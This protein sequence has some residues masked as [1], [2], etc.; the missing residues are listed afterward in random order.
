MRRTITSVSV[1]LTVTAVAVALSWLGVRSVLRDTVFEAPRAP[2]LTA[3]EDL[4]PSPTHAA[5]ATAPAPI[6]NLISATNRTTSAP[7]TTPKP[8]PSTPPGTPSPPGT[9]STPSTPSAPATQG[10][11]APPAAAI[12]TMGWPPP[13]SKMDD[14]GETRRGRSVESFEVRGGRASFRYGPTSATLVAATPK[15]GW[16]VKVWPN[17]AWIRV[18][19]TNGGHTSSVIVAWNDQEPIASTHED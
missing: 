8:P 5:Q 15:P 17:P 18:D 6:P 10:A 2:T 12:P 13:L 1:W 3:D 16:S 4:L 11:A 19:F 7:P 9:S 14:T